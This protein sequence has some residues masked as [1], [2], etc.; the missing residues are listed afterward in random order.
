MKIMKDGLVTSVFH[1]PVVVSSNGR[2][3]SL[4]VKEIPDKEPEEMIRVSL[5]IEYS[6]NLK[7]QIGKEVL[8][9]KRGEGGFSQIDH[10]DMRKTL[11]LYYEPTLTQRFRIMATYLSLFFFILYTFTKRLRLNSHPFDG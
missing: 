1:L 11:V 9:V 6:S 2:N 7:A 5:P 4:Q 3:L 8:V 10:E